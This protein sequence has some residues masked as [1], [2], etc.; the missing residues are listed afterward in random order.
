MM[1]VT[2]QTLAAAEIR[3]QKQYFESLVEISPVAVVTMDRTSVVSGWNP[4]ATR[5]FGYAP[6]EAIGRRIDDLIIGHRRDARGGR[7]VARRGPRDR[8]VGAD[9]RP[10][11]PQGRRAVDV[12]IV[13]VPLVI[14]GEHTG[15]LRHLPRHHRAPGGARARPRPPTRPRAHSWRR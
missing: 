9:H 12:E 6:D 3:R 2:E 15:L 13:M 8:P 10:A 1:D 7:G 4:A 11:R 14:D 5:L